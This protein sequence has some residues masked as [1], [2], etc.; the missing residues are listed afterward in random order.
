MTPY[1]DTN[2]FTHLLVPLEKSA[3]AEALSAKLRP[4]KEALPVIWLIRME[5][6]NAL[7]RLVFQSRHE[8]QAYPVSP[9]FALMAEARLADEMEDGRV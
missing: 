2:F 5:L 3:E 4:T 6:T 7:Q 8:P 1:A 9:E